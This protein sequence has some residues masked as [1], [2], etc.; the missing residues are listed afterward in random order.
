MKRWDAIAALVPLFPDALVIACNGMI[1]RDLFA[2]GDRASRFYMIGSM[3]LASS[4]GLGLA[5]AQPRRRVVVLDGDGNVLMNLGGLANV[6]A[7]GPANLYHVILDNGTHASTGDQ[8]TIS[9]LVRLEA[10][11]R[12]AGYR[13]VWRVREGQSLV[14]AAREFLAA[15][16]PVCLLIEVEPGN[17]PKVPR[18]SVEAPEITAR[19]R[20]EA[21]K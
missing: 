12:A 7:A 16:G 4:I 17:Q 5:L 19:F 2:T 18:V 10:V 21:M 20:A 14:R 9:P 3:G 15:Q 8:K 11:A 6:A 1:G 13:Q